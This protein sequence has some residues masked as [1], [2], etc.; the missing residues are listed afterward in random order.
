MANPA[1]SLESLRLLLS[2]HPIAATFHAPIYSN[3]AFQLLAMAY[4]QI[5]H[6]D[7]DTAVKRVLLDPL[8]LRRT[9]WRPPS[10]DSNAAVVEQLDPSFSRTW[11][12][13][14]GIQ[15]P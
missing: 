1:S 12:Y 5:T 10:N 7:F 9:F 6:E 13:D 2:T 14:L 8:G 3:P 11:D 15:G 4:E